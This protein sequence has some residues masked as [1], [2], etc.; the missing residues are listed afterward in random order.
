VRELGIDAADTDRAWSDLVFVLDTD[1][2]VDG[3]VVDLD[4]E[5]FDRSPGGGRRW[6]GVAAALVVV[7]GLAATFVAIQFE[8]GDGAAAEPMGPWLLPAA[9][10]GFTTSAG[11]V[12]ASSVDVDVEAITGSASVAGRRFGDGY[13]DL[14]RVTVADGA[15][16]D[17][18]PDPELVDTAAGE[19]RRIELGDT[20]VFLSQLRGERWITTTSPLDG[21]QI[22]IELLSAATLEPDGT[23]AFD[24][25]SGFELLETVT[26]D[27]TYPSLPTFANYEV[28]GPGIDQYSVDP[29]VVESFESRQTLLGV[30]AVDD[31]ARRVTIHGHPGWEVSRSDADGESSVY[32][33]NVDGVTFAVYGGENAAIT[34]AVADS[35]VTVDEATWR[36]ATGAGPPKT[37]VSTD[38]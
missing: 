29:V 4:R 36:E 28:N 6:L 37:M 32:A 9:G 1:V 14:V 13:H 23:L 2:V 12:E 8:S 11:F 5:R 10:S 31:V 34:R 19:V 3:V 7:V 15:P 30:V 21:E 25:T 22:A 26:F 24:P 16:T 35:L 33:W 17:M 18:L 27:G 38:P 20:L